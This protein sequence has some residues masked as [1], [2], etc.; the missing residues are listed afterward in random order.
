MVSLNSS[1]NPTP[2]LAERGMSEFHRLRLT[3]VDFDVADFL[4]SEDDAVMTCAEIGQ[5][6][7]LLAHA[8]LG[9]KDATLPGDPI[10]LLA[11]VL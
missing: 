3:K 2:S 1:W 10:R 11:E 5:L 6:V 9:G 4:E 7:L 8:W